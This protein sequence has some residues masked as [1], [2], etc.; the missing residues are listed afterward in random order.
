M[1]LFN[2]FLCESSLIYNVHYYLMLHGI[3]ATQ[4]ALAFLPNLTF[5]LLLMQH[6]SFPSHFQFQCCIVC[7]KESLSLSR[8]LH[9]AVVWKMG[10]CRCS[11]HILSVTAEKMRVSFRMPTDAHARKV[12]VSFHGS[13]RPTCPVIC[14]PL[15]VR[16]GN[17]EA[18]ACSDLLKMLPFSLLLQQR[19][20]M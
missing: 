12:I 5:R 9:P 7:K 13:G 2:L 6:I 18:L 19:E 1:K 15:L 20:V 8:A 4:E 3:V 14:C 16:S 10:R 17:Y 11:N